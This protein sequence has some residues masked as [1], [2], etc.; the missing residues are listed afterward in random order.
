MNGLG[1]QENKMQ[2][3]NKFHYNVN[4]MK[5]GVIIDFLV[6]LINKEL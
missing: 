4:N 2:K 3:I 5:R 6:K 1:L